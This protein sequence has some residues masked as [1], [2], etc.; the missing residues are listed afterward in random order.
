MSDER[1]PP[2]AQ[3]TAPSEAPSAPRRLYWDF[4]GPH[5]E[6]TAAHFK[7]HLDEF[8]ARNALNGCVTG[9]ESERPGHFAAFCRTPPAVEAALIR[10]L[11]PQ[12]AL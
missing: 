8:L 11:R 3:G 5:A 7:Q 4:F 1:V 10:A 12:R 6:R 2:E 9:T